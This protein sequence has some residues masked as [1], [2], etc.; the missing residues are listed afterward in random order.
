MVI[1]STRKT[2][3]FCVGEIVRVRSRAAIIASFDSTEG[4]D[5][6][7]FTRQMAESCGRTF[8]VS[9]VGRTL[10]DEHKHRNCRPRAPFYI[11]EH[12]I[13]DGNADGSQP[14]CDHSCFFLWHADWLECLDGSG[15]LSPNV[16]VVD[17]P[18]GSPTC[19]LR[20]I[21]R[22]SLQNSWLN[23]TRQKWIRKLRWYRRRLLSSLHSEDGALRITREEQDEIKAGDIVRVKS[24][25]EINPTLDLHRKTRGCTFQTEMYEHCGM[26]YRVLK[27]IG[28]FFDE[29]SRKTRKCKNTYLLEGCCCTGSGTYLGT[30]D[31]NCFF[32]W[33]RQWL[34]KV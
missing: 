27:K 9:K 33:Q 2:G 34:D 26:E 32:F 11:L 12:S 15:I 8:R 13:C 17:I 3:T 22:V 25:D 5:G 4:L 10:F 31:R 29:A 14:V 7:I 23:E 16:S 1:T 24:R 21:D 30:C 20:H 28:H 18:D 6:L 19:Q